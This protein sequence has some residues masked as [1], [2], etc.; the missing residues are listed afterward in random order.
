MANL[1]DIRDRI[2][3]VKSIQKVTKAMKMVSAAKMRRAQERMEE[4]RPYSQSLQDVIHHI[5]PDVDRETLPLLDVR[6]IKRKAYVVVSADRGLSGSFNANVLK[7]A[8]NEIDTFGKENID[9]FCI[10]KKA[11]DHFKRREYNII[12]SHVD[13]WAE[14]EFDSAM[15]IGRSIIDHFVS[16]KVDEI[17]VVYNY[18]INVGQQEVKS[19]VLL[20]L[21]YDENESKTTDRLYEPSKDALV[22]SLIPRHLNVQM[23]KYL[24]ESYAS[25]QAARMMAMENAT[26][27]AQDMIKDLTLQFNKARQAAITTEMLE[28]VSGA[29]ALTE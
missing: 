10:G 8:Q 16:G 2:K 18:F 5:L 13:F 21:V 1:K 9:L 4:S 22:Q 19:E 14:M 28:I 15:M 25:E 11:R 6:E 17:H 3:S 27:N 26:T 20:P 23:W 12:E 7:E 29:E 24:L